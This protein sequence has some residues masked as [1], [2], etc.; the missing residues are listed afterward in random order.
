MTLYLGWQ[1]TVIL[2]GYDAVKEALVDQADDFTGRGPLPFLMKVTNGYGNTRHFK[3]VISVR[4]SVI[5]QWFQAC[6]SVLGFS[7]IAPVGQQAY[8][9]SCQAWG[10][11]TGSAGAS[12]DVSH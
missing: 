2:V 8:I 7:C 9:F 5:F 4:G 11:V 3:S 6:M 1:R 12:C 10:S